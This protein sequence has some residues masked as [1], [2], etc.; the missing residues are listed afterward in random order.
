MVKKTTIM[1]IQKVLFA[2]FLL[3]TSIAYAQSLSEVKKE[4]LNRILS[5]HADQDAPG[6]AVG[7]V[8]DGKVVYEQYLGYS[9]LGHQIKI[10]ENTRFN[11]ASNAKQFTA[12]CVLK[13]IQE[14]KLRLDDDIR[15]YLPDLYKDIED[16]IT[17]ANLLVHSSGVR[18]VYYLWSLK[19]QTWYELFVDND[20]AMELLQAQEALNFKP[21][22]E[23]LYSN[24]NYILLAEIVKI[25]ADQDF[26][27][28]AKTMFEALEMPS[29]S[30][31][32]NHMDVI[33]NKA[34]PYAKWGAWKEYPYITEIH[35]DGALFTTLKDQLQWEQI[36]QVNQGKYLSKNLIRE[37]QA[38]LE[39]SI[40]H[41]GYGLMFDQYKGLNYTYHDGS[42]GAYKAT[43][44]RFPAKNVA[45]VLNSNNGSV[46][47]NYL[48][49]QLAD[50]VFD[51]SD[52]PAYPGNP[53][54]IEKLEKLR[55][56]LGHYQN[57]VGTIIKIVEKEGSLYREI[58]Q[59]DPVKLIKENGALFEYETIE[60]LKMNFTN[61]G[62]SRQQFTIYRSSQA[63][64][65]YHKLE[66]VELGNFDKNG[67]NGTFYNKETDTSIEITFLNNDT[68][69]VRKNGRERMAEMVIKD[70]LQ[71]NAYQ[72]SIIR[73]PKDIVI[74]LNIDNNRIK[75]VIFDRTE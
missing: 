46:P 32:T 30:F 9:N 47:T 34:R 43:F 49:K 74:G 26:S 22:T 16:R 31:L 20:D 23:Y 18:D 67:L 35:G 45:I 3:T 64:S 40:T 65:T 38:P 29:T 44:L 17:I 39:N 62:T 33:P 8:K 52:I 24:S 15:T 72:I 58:Y 6:L 21:G 56:I 19:G 27:E 54:K 14:G 41:Y 60:G 53:E 51:L 4:A 25:V 55:D 10:D 57:D 66:D 2:I 68:Y 70:L 12:L 63:P 1:S 69:S 36:V 42:T 73:D 59:S 5:Q 71:M 28:V 11:I 37:S 61:I 48:A 50:I 75:N 7:I 13:L